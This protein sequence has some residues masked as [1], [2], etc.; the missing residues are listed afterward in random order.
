MRIVSSIRTSSL[1]PLTFLWLIVNTNYKFI[2]KLIEGVLS[3]LI[4]ETHLILMYGQVAD[5]AIHDMR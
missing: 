3:K 5:S 4:N 2:I 1:P